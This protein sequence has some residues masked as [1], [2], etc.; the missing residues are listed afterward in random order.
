M[1]ADQFSRRHA[2]GCTPQRVTLGYSD[3]DGITLDFVD[4]PTAAKEA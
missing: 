2:L 1:S 3:E 4:A